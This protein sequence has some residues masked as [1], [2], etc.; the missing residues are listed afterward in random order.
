LVSIDARLPND[1][2][3]EALIAG[4]GPFKGPFVI[5]RE[6]AFG[7][8]R[9]DF[10]LSGGD[11]RCLLEAKSVTLVKD[12]RALFPDAPTLRGRR[13]LQSLLEAKKAGYEAAVVFVAQR[14]DAKDFSPND[15]TDPEFGRILREVQRQ[16]VGVYAYAC[17]VS[18]SE[19]R[20]AK[21][22]PVYL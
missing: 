17:K 16:G 10:L 5:K 14:E 20:L 21:E 12:S 1:L 11:W 8:S 9:L 18:T 7:E 15:E 4:D 6:A 22:I 19:V 2:V 13:H 3:H